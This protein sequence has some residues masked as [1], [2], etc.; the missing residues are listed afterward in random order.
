MT[1]RQVQA[2]VAVAQTLSFARACE[3]LHLSQPA[4]SLAIRNLEK[5]LGGALFTR[6]TRQVRLTPEGL[7]LLPQALQLL[8]GW[9]NVREQARERFALQRGHVTVAAMPS[10]AGSLLPAA[11]REFRRRHPNVHVAVQDVINEQVV[12]LVAT[13]RVEL[14]I[15]FE[16]DATAGLAFERLFVDRFVAIVPRDSD[17]AKGRSVTWAQLFARDFI[18]LHRPSAMRRMLEETL[19]AHGVALHVTAE[20]HQLATV[21]ALVAGGLG[22]SVVPSL[23]E[24]H[25]RERGARVLALRTPVI[26]QPVGQLYREGHELSTAAGAL[27][28]VLRERLR[29]EA[30]VG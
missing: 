25:V 1:P 24:R 20:S 7:A 19:A 5:E 22:V 16:P 9:D 2:F 6:T 29:G 26:Q 21:V 30:G 17:L 12:E 11:L 3:R 4:L 27:Q 10:V 13:G 23:L 18:T 28:A 8:A 14:G 15:A